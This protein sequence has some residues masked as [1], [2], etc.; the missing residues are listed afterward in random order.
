MLMFI[1]AL[2][3][4]CTHGQATWIGQKISFR[5]RS[6]AVAEVYEKAPRR[7]AVARSSTVLGMKATNSSDCSESVD[8]QVNVGTIINLMSV[9][10][11]HLGEVGASLYLL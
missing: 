11:F 2:L 8:T 1:I 10:A 9:D 6:I 3:S 4:A 7:K 5:L